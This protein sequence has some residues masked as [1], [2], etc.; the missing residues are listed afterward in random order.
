MSDSGWALT[1]ACNRADA[2]AMPEI[3]E[4]FP[5]LPDPPTLNVEEPDPDRPDAW[6]MT[7]YFAGEPDP[8]LGVAAVRVR[9]LK[10]I[11]PLTGEGALI[12]EAPAGVPD[13]S[14]YDLGNSWF[15]ERSA[16]FGKF[17]VV[18]AMISMHFATAPGAKRP[19]TLNIE[20]AKPNGS[21]LK[22]LPEGDRAIAEAHIARWNLIE[23]AA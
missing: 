16:I 22:D 4:V 3:G 9:R 19:K 5:D 23:P 17:T 7:A 12:V 15:A 18:Q 2:E 20:L 14:V 11:G 10:L 21:N 6:V 8:A 1:L 13:R